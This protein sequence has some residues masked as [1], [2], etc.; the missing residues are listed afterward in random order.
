MTEVPLLPR[1]S[2]FVQL[3]ER[4]IKSPGDPKQ[5]FIKN[6]IATSKY[7]CATFLPKNMWEQFHKLANV[8][9]LIIAV[10]QSIPQISVTGGI[11]NILLPLTF[12]LAVSAFKDLLEDNKR[13][14]S[15]DEENSRETYRRSGGSWE[16]VD[17]RSVQV[18]DIQ[19]VYKDQF[20][21]A[22]MILL[23]SSEP[24]GICFVE[25]KNLDGETN[26]KHKLSHKDTHV[27]MGNEAN[28][29][30]LEF[31]LNCEGPNS[32]IY[33]FN[34]MLS[35]DN[36]KVALTNEQFL[37]RGCSL[38]NTAWVVGLVVYT[39]H[40]TKIMLN[41]GRS[42]SKSSSIEMT[43][44]SQIIL[45]FVMQVCICATCAIF[46]SIWYDFNLKSTASYLDLE[47]RNLDVIQQGIY[48][49]F[50]WML[51]FSNFVP[52]SLIVTLETVKFLQAQFLSSDI[53]MYYPP[54]D[55]PAKVQSSN[56]NEELGQIS[57]VFSDKTGTLT[58]NVMEFKKCSIAGKS[59]G[60][61]QQMDASDKIPYVNFC[62][63]ALDHENSRVVDFF[64][65]LATCHTVVAEEED[66]KIEY[67][68]SSPDELALVNAAKYFGV[69]FLGRD[70]E[71][72]M[73][74]D[75]HGDPCVIRILNV[76]EFNSVRKRMSV[77]CEMPDGAIK[78][79]VKG[80]DSVLLPRLVPS[81]LIATTWQH[82]E[83]YAEEGLRTLVIAAKNL[84]PDEYLAWAERYH[85]AMCDIHDREHRIEILAEEI[86]KDL[87]LI[88][89][90]A[91][92]DR[93]QDDVPET[94]AKLK[95]AGLKVWVLT[96]D[97]IETAINIG[98]SCCLLHNDM[99]Q[100]V[101]Q[102]IRTQ[103]VKEEI[104]AAQQTIKMAKS[105]KMFALIVAGEALIKAMSPE[106]TPELMI[107]AK[108]CDVVLCCRV[109]PQQ[110]AQVV[111]MVRAA[112]PG[113]RTLAI[114]DGAND[115]NMISAAHVGIGISGL[116]GQQ[117]VR[118]SDFAIAQFSY[119][120]RLMFLHGRE[121]YR[122]NSV[123]V[124]FNFYKN[125]LLTMPLFWYGVISVFSGQ[126]FYNAWNLQLYNLVYAACPI[127]FYALFDRQVEA[128]ELLD[129]PKH[130]K[131]GLL[132]KHF[133][134]KVFWTWIVEA[135][136]QSLCILAVVMAFLNPMT[137]D[138][139][140]GRMTNLSIA[141]SCVFGIV[142][143]FANFKIY[144]VSFIHYWFSLTAQVV[145][146]LLYFTT[147]L[148][149][150]ELLPIKSWLNNFDSRGTFFIMF[151]VPNFYLAALL[152]LVVCFGLKPVY[153]EIRKVIVLWRKVRNAPTYTIV[154]E[155]P[156]SDE[157]LM[158]INEQSH[159]P[160]SIAPAF[161]PKSRKT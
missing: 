141:G 94:I 155:E 128:K 80:A 115:V 64:T 121:S 7:N 29:D 116:E 103:E 55:M 73:E 8:Y 47:S 95:E 132:H 1:T 48:Q 71:N 107:V 52:I 65:H 51:I 14:R 34:A 118:A 59:Y 133:N 37:L 32:R 77:I 97:K 114:G 3:G 125:I 63:E 99:T 28:L 24:K 36:Q 139:E 87:Y 19:I 23:T 105:D 45:I 33:T 113:V 146:V 109:S 9:F 104:I 69:H 150:N 106:M 140:H 83:G 137:N 79:L 12:V 72:N 68:A 92:E 98:Y 89:A 135:M 13:K 134:T 102:G 120:Q 145:S 42:K 151:T 157:E 149:L 44:N 25:T 161:T 38:R 100:I 54:Y 108:K 58:C 160:F 127:V 4:H 22:D 111:E 122:K 158:P 110:K 2:D 6:K 101:I 136:F 90:T 11:P 124:C 50:S 154:V 10:L 138:S 84:E 49:F 93:L 39:G 148:L 41:S 20:F 147:V 60:T 26:M 18:G 17:W 126:L 78:L 62:D 131:I 144:M 61:N 117:A 152:V 57:Y 66:H 153:R 88:G 35:F 16:R 27:F 74:I 112:L 81:P 21:P 15:D 85:D 143:M 40:E 142:V 156:Q 46:S 82:M 96:G 119:L 75:M 86:E 130:Y 76:I 91:I 67:K 123:L 56:L 30:G 43:M 70:K 159:R 129:N 31:S 53:D 5:T